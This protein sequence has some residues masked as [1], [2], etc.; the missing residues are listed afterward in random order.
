MDRAHIVL[1]F[2]FVKPKTIIVNRMNGYQFHQWFLN[3]MANVEPITYIDAY[4]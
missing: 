2:S 1:F 4:I 3:E